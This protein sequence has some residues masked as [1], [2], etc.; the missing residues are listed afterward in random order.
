M[1]C[2]PIARSMTHSK[3]RLE[4]LYIYRSSENIDSTSFWCVAL[5]WHACLVTSE[6]VLS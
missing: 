1:R 5:V 2:L 4:I 3:G 6:H